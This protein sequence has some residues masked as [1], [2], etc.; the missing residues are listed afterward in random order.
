MSLF[1]VFIQQG[2]I[3]LI[4]RDSK[5]TFLFIKE[6]E[7]NMVSTKILF[8]INKVLT[9]FWS[10]KCILEQETSFKNLL[11]SQPFER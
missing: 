2:C 8:E 6:S 11:L 1:N 7:K 4:K 10:N 3:Q 5:D 9:V